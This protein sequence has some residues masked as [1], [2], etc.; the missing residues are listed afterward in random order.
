MPHE[1][2]EGWAFVPR[3]I[4]G[5]GCIFLLAK[6]L[7]SAVAPG[8]E[9]LK[10]LMLHCTAHCWANFVREAAL[11]K[12]DLSTAVRGAQGRIAAMVPEGITVMKLCCNR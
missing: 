5:G 3:M 12:R 7:W 2:P 4:P 10:S 6:C 8:K 11:C 9:P 1:E